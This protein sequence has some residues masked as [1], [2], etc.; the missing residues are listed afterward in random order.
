MRHA[1]LILSWSPIM[2][3]VRL[4]DGSSN[5]VGLV[6]YLRLRRSSTEQ[7][8]IRQPPAR[9][10]LQIVVIFHEHRT[11]GL[12]QERE[13]EAKKVDVP[14]PWRPPWK[15]ARTFGFF[16]KE[17]QNIAQDLLSRRADPP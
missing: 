12:A 2:Q 9:L 5:C 17:D 14:I 16:K 8:W 7:L 11:T 10:R 3:G 15:E 13:A 6:A 4:E 1:I